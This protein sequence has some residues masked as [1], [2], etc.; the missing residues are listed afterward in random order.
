MTTREGNI[1]PLQAENEQSHQE[2]PDVDEVRRRLNGSPDTA[3]AGGF[4]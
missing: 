1:Q 4:R 3:L 2:I